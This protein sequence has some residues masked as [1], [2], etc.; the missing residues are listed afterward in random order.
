MPDVLPRVLGWRFL[1]SIG[2]RC[3][4]DRWLWLRRLLRQGSVR[5]F[6]AGYGNGFSIFAAQAGN[7]E[8]AASFLSS[9]QES[10]RRRDLSV[11]LCAV[12]RPSPG[13]A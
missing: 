3:V 1:L 5:T 4:L 7:E 11:A 10:A 8:V 6:A 9:E 12:K 2:D 13:V